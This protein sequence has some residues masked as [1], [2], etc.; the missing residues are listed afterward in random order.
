MS[1][2]QP[3]KFQQAITG[4]WHGLPSVF[5][6][7]GTHVGFNKVDRESKYEDGVTTYYMRTDFQNVGPLRYRF[8]MGSES[9]AFGVIDSDQNRVYCGPDFMGSGRP[10]GMLVDSN[11]YSPG[12]N[13]DLR[14]LNL[15]LPEHGIQVYSSELYEGPVMAAVFNG[16]YIVT[17]DYETN[18]DTQKRVDD[19]IESERLN[20]KKAFLLPV[21][22]AGQWR[23]ELETYDGDQNLLGTAEVVIDHTPLTLLRSRMD[24]SIS[25]TITR[26]FSFE[27]AH[28]G[29]VH[30]FE[31]PDVWGNG[32]SYGRYLFS[33]QHFYGEPV[34][35]RARDAFIDNDF[36]LC[37]VWQFYEGNKERYTTFGVLEW[38][39]G[40]TVLEARY[41][42]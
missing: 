31:G 21:K 39:P 25:G 35:I 18:P 24:V 20:A 38:S 26:K 19:F 29:N 7:D 23:G 41:V 22:T 30:T 2:K 36:S 32:R 9:M 17:Q 28:N 14:T 11:Y 27:R 5:E 8:D 37:V 34:K 6:P 33:T 42:S 3:S 12:W 13:T 15:V 10:Y 40:D 4:T 1:S 16:I